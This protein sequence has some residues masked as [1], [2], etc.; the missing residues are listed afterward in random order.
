MASQSRTRPPG[1]RCSGLFLKRLT[2]NWVP[3]WDFDAP[4]SQPWKDNSAGGTAAA[5]LLHLS[6]VASS[7]TLAKKYQTAALA[8]LQ[9]LAAGYLSNAAPPGQPLSGYHVCYLINCKLHAFTSP[10][11]GSCTCR[12]RRLH[13]GAGARLDAWLAFPFPSQSLVHLLTIHCM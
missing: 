11:A 3:L 7:A 12:P 2:P 9:A 10:I 5:G 13:N 4:P 8:M 1:S 6:K